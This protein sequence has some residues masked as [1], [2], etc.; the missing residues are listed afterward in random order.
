MKI[1]VFIFY[2]S[3]STEIPET[4]SHCPSICPM[5]YFPICGS[6]GKTYGNTCEMKVVACR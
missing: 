4:E 3:A 5:I 6:D 1:Q 2:I